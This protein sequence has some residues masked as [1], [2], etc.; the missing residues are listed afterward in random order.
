MVVDGDVKN[1]TECN[2]N[3]CRSDTGF[4]EIQPGIIEIEDGESS[5]QILFNI[6]EGIY[7]TYS[8]S[9]LTLIEPLVGTGMMMIEVEPIEQSTSFESGW[10]A[11]TTESTDV[12][13]GPGSNYSS[14]EI[15]Q[16]GTTGIIQDHMNQLN[17]VYAKD[18][19][20]WKVEFGSVI[21]WVK[22]ETLFGWD[23]VGSIKTYLPS[24]SR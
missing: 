23:N 6:A 10:Y 15:I 19:F 1:N 13:L 22:E 7:G 17:G 16:E 18:S 14:L 20:W 5:D 21:G 2:F 3:D 8:D 9:D 12:R 4:A 24:V 11:R